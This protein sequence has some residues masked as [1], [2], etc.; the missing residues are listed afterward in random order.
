[1]ATSTSVVIFQKNLQDLVKGIRAQKRDLSQ[2]I[3]QSIAD[4]K[5]EL[6]SNDPF[7]KAEAVC[8]YVMQ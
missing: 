1:M 2:F 5:S 8:N 3:S 4:I 6:R 7:T